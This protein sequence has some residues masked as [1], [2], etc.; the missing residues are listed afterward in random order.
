VPDGIKVDQNGNIFVT[1]PKVS[2]L[3][4]LRYS[5]CMRD[6]GVGTLK[7]TIL[8]RSTCPT[9]PPIW[10]GE[11]RTT[12]RFTL[13][14]PRLYIKAIDNFLTPVSVFLR[15]ASNHRHGIR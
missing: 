8:A 5:G 4:T 13:Q 15:W 10:H 2:A 9:S 1:R 3:N 7:G 14:P 6:M 12:A 11:T